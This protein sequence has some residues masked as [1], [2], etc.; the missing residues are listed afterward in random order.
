MNQLL[1]V[2]LKT[3]PSDDTQIHTPDSGTSGGGG[4]NPP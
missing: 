4:K 2:S 1:I 3:Y